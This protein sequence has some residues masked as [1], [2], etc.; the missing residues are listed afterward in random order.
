[1]MHITFSGRSSKDIAQ[2]TYR[3]GTGWWRWM[4]CYLPSRTCAIW[5]RCL[6]G[7]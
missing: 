5:H 3:L 7:T 2:W 1:M 4:C 6:Q